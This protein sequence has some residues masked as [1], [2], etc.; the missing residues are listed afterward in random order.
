M[1]KSCAHSKQCLSSPVFIKNIICVLPQFLHI[2]VDEHQM[3]LQPDK[4][5]VILV[6]YLP[7]VSMTMNL[8]AVRSLDD[9]VCVTVFLSFLLCM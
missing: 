6:V 5:M 2:C 9:A 3:D 8:V 4:V 1:L 7:W